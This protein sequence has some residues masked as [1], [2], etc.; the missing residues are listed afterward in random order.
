MVARLLHSCA[1]FLGPE[2]ELMQPTS[3]NPEGYWEHMRFVKLNDRIIAQFGGLWN[4][5]PPF[6]AGWEYA[7]EVDPLLGEAEELIG[8]FRGYHN[9]GW[10][11]PRNSLT[12]PFW[13]RLIPD[14]K[15]VVC[16]RNPL[17]VARSL[18]E[19]GDTTSAS[20]FR[21]WL[22]YYRQ[23]LSAVP[24]KQRIVT[25]YQSYFQDARPEVRRVSGW[26]GLRVSD[27]TVDRAP[28]HVSADL[29][30]HHVMTAEL[31]AVG[32]PD[33]V[34][35][36]YLSLCAEAGTVY[37]HDREREK[38][39]ELRRTDARVSM[40]ETYPHRLRL[41]RIEKLHLLESELAE[42]H[43][44][45]ASL[46]ATPQANRPEPSYTKTLVRAFDALCAVKM[47]LWS[48]WQQRQP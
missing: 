36:L 29:R 16:V 18:F 42:H 40:P 34:I 25:H 8:R 13:R 11:D 44:G 37:R 20:Q 3:A 1:L 17:E 45:T 27:E 15:V 43:A 7:P 39:A 46:N 10:K 23:L 21:L 5:P 9:W 4:D 26:C 48:R 24:P 41:K 47:R 32:V 22:T 35:H 6:P 30:H 12:L 31:L 28:A 2:E 33:E 38:V 19:R 14:L